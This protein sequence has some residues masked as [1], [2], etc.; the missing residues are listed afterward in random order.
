MWRQ[1]PRM[2]RQMA[3]VEH[4]EGRPRSRRGR[5]A[6][7]RSSDGRARRC[8]R[9][10]AEVSMTWPIDGNAAR[11]RASMRMRHDRRMSVSERTGRFRTR[12]ARSPTPSTARGRGPSCCCTAC[13]SASACTSRSPAASPSAATA[14]SR[15]TCSATATRTGRLDPRLL[16]DDLLRPADDRAARPP[17]GRGGGRARHLARRQHGARGGGAAPPS[18]CAAWSSRCRCSTARCSPARSRSRR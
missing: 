1:K 2:P 6:T 16:L 7:R 5:A 11:S 8:G 13:C 14:W 18:G 3:V 10:A 12:G 4:L 17:R 9:T 15:S